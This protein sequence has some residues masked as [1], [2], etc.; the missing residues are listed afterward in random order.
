[1]NPHRHDFDRAEQVTCED[2]HVYGFKDLHII[3]QQVKPQEHKWE[4][5][6]DDAVFQSPAWN[7]IENTAQFW[8]IYSNRK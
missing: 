5:V 7:N 1:M 6:F 3:R 4:R 2:D 8:K